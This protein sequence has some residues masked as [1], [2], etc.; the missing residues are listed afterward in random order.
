MFLPHLYVSVKSAKSSKEL[1][2]IYEYVLHEKIWYIL[3]SF[4]KVILFQLKVSEIR[5]D[6]ILTDNF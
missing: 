4:V 1:A 3:Q 2:E 5:K 6:D